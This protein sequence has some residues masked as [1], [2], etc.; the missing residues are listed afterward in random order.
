MKRLIVVIVVVMAVSLLA[1]CS[2]GQTEVVEKEVTKIVTEKIVETVVV[3]GTPEVI[4]REVTKVVEV[5]KVVT[6]TPEQAEEAQE[7]Q[8]G[9]T[10]VLGYESEPPTLDIH[11]SPYCGR[12]FRHLGA[13]LISKDPKT[14]EY[15]PY[16]AESWEMSEDGLTWDFH[17]REGITFHNG[18]PLTAEDFRWTYERV[19]DPATQAPTAGQ[20]LGPVD[21][22]EVVDDHTLRLV[23]S[24]PFYPLLENLELPFTQP[25]SKRAVE[26]WGDQYGRHPVGV[27]PYK[28]KE[29]VTGDKL[30]LERYADYDWAPPFLHAGPAY[31][32]TIEY[33]YIPEYATMLAGLEAGEVDFAEIVL[34][35][36]VERLREL[37]TI[38]VYEAYMGGMRPY[39]SMNVSQAPFDSLEVRQ[40]FNYA[41]NK[42]AL[43]QIVAGGHGVPQYGPA[44]HVTHGYWDGVEEIGYRFDPEK[45]KGLLEEAGYT[46]GS[47]GIYEKDGEPLHIVLKAEPVAPFNKVAEVLQQQYR[48]VGIDVEIEQQEYSLMQGDLMGGTYQAAVYGYDYTEFYVVWVFFHSDNIGALNFVRQEN[49]EL[50]GYLDSSAYELDPEKRQEAVNEA[51][52]VIV[53]QAYAVP[54]YTP[55]FFLPMNARV[56]GASIDTF[57]GTGNQLYPNDLW[58]AE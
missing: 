39:V 23:L 13:T 16:L 41:V 42:D 9:G 53:E 57:S 45:A 26:E 11:L 12:E 50:D 18:D 56:K 8:V 43:I 5:E 2:A 34:A 1:S 6:P 14:G 58:I 19:L 31:I 7:P 48:E 44:S 22:V 20:P 10:L 37:G 3:E 51:Q 35:K 52:R 15:L 38:N 40:A 46:M 25:L 36:D 17:L 55:T 21:S 47:D 27:G 32:E 49:P 4:E 30:I 28:F 54:L 24:Q 29:W 33:R